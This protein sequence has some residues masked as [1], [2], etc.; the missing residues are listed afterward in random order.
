MP[1]GGKKK[2]ECSAVGRTFMVKFGASQEN[3]SYTE[4]PYHT[5]MEMFVR[6]KVTCHLCVY[7]NMI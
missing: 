1:F 4:P 5:D 3:I 6:G 2:T 7:I